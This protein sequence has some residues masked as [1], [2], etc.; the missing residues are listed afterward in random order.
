MQIPDRNRLTNQVRER[1][2]IGKWID[3]KVM[4]HSINSH[5]VNIDPRQS[6]VRFAV[7]SKSIITPLQSGRSLLITHQRLDR[8]HHMNNLCHLS[9]FCCKICIA[10]IFWCLFPTVTILDD[11]DTS[12]HLHDSSPKSSSNVA[13]VSKRQSNVLQ[14][15]CDSFDLEESEK[16]MSNHNSNQLSLCHESIESTEDEI[17]KS[18]SNLHIE[19]SRNELETQLLKRCG[20][21]HVLGFNEI[22]SARYRIRFIFDRFSHISIICTFLFVFLFS[23][24]FQFFFQ[25]IVFCE[26]VRKSAKVF[27]VKFF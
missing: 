25:F 12:I 27:S 18:T 11:S 13:L 4:L 24:S 7:V 6:I 9:K 20:Q 8:L 5:C 22:Y 10:Y 16:S 19:C 26:S 14:T 3:W 23:V 1:S 21:T 15:I 17:E 2:Q